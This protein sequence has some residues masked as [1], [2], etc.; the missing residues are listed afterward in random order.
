MN[1]T[2]TRVLCGNCHDYHG[3][4]D[5]VRACYESRR[6]S[7]LARAERLQDWRSPEATGQRIDPR[8]L[9][10]PSLAQA[11]EEGIFVNRETGTPHY[12]KVVQGTNTGNFYVKELVVT[13]HPDDEG[14]PTFEWVYAGRRP[15]HFLKVTD[16][17]T[18]E[19]AAAFG[20]LTGR[21]VFCSRKLTDERSIEVGYGQ[22]CAARE[23]LP[24]GEN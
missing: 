14:G 11:P 8:I 16:R 17:A 4:A 3:S 18:A 2:I 6:D 10:E 13:D 21:C 1:D 12:Y 15:L 22:T 24:W 20:A 5:E 23:G 19:E 7:I 9:G